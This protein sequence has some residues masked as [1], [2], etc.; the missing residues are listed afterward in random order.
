MVILTFIA[1]L[2]ES[3]WFSHSMFY[4]R[5]DGSSVC[6]SLNRGFLYIQVSL[7]CDLMSNRRK[8]TFR[9]ARTEAIFYPELWRPNGSTLGTTRLGG[10]P[11]WPI[12]PPKVIFGYLGSNYLRYSQYYGPQ[13]FMIQ[14]H[15]FWMFA[16]GAAIVGVVKRKK[17]FTR[18]SGRGFPLSTS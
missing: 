8:F 11:G 17:F 1:L 18:R 4:L 2:L 13:V 3:Y 14:V 7:P 10:C 12:W 9:N 6:A 16:I 5:C 15:Y